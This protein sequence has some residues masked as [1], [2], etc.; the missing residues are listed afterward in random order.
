MSKR[1]SEEQIITSLK[2]AEAGEP[3]VD[4]CRHEGIGVV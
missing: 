1:K 4:L 3:I 2:R